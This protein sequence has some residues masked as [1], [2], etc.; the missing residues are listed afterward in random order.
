[1]LLHADHQT[2][3]RPLHKKDDRKHR[4]MNYSIPESCLVCFRIDA[5]HWYPFVL[6]VSGDERSPTNETPTDDMIWGDVEWLRLYQV[7]TYDHSHTCVCLITIIHSNI[8]HL[9]VLLEQNFVLLLRPCTSLESIS[10]NICVW[11]HQLV[12]WFWFYPYNN[13]VIE[14]TK[15]H[16]YESVWLM[17]RVWLCWPWYQDLNIYSSVHDTDS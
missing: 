2:Q 7:N 8:T 16:T 6:S 9:G 13:C 3:T 1:M 5:W 15:S 10:V 11:V 17:M 12:S 4:L 14:T